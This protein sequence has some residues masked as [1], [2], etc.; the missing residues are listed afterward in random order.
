M[1]GSPPDYA[2]LKP[3]LLD[4]LFAAQTGLSEYELLRTLARALPYFNI[5][6]L[7][8][9]ALFQRHFLLFHCLYRLQQDLWKHASGQ[10]AISALSIRLSAYQP[11]QA[12]QLDTADPLRAYYLDPGHLVSTGQSELDA[13]LGSFWTRLARR[14]HRTEALAMLGLADPI[15]DSAIK[16]RYRELVMTHHPDR[17]GDTARIQILNAAMSELFPKRASN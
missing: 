12:R 2:A 13:L 3:R 16:Q 6:G 17:G 8:T 4:I 1:Q 10:L 9:L 11:G 14:G 7:D 5:D 15:E